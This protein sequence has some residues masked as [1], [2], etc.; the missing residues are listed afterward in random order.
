MTEPFIFHDLGQIPYGEALAMQQEAFGALLASKAR[1]E[2]GDSVLFFCEHRPVFTLGKSGR[3]ANLLV[4]EARL[5]AQG[6]DFYRTDRGGDIT[7]HGP[8]QITG[9]PV[10]DLETFH[11]GLRQYVERMEDVMIRFLAL[12]GLR[13]GRLAG[14]AGVW[15]EPHTARARKICAV[16][17]KSSRFV[18]MHGFALNIRTELQHFSLIN[19]CGF[20]DRGV[21]SLRR[22]LGCEVD[23]EEAKRRLRAL[24]AEAFSLR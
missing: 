1:G 8:G 11:I 16:G 6:F 15:L 21:T 24:F 23:F 2:A 12:Y 3:M 20:A 13:G 17:V 10:F 9:Y 18:T 7:Y 5:K 14:A 4:S 19:P 22:E